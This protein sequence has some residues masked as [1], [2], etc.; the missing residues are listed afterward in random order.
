MT[1]THSAHAETKLLKQGTLKTYPGSPHAMPNI[2][3]DEVNQNLLE[4]LELYRS[5]RRSLR[6]WDIA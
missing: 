6:G 4:L 3:I 2:V 5:K 1:W